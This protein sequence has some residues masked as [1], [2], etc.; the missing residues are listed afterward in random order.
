MIFF[1]KTKTKKVLE[2]LQLLAGYH[3]VPIDNPQF[4]LQ[5]RHMYALIKALK[6]K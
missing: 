2:V 3:A 6:G 5:Y 4:M 1:R